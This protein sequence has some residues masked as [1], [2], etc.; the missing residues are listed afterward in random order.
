[1]NKFL[2]LP[3]EIRVTRYEGDIELAIAF[4]REALRD[5]CLGLCLLKAR[6]IEELI[7]T[8][9]QPRT[10]VK[11]RPG[12]KPDADRTTRVTIDPETSLLEISASHLDDALL[13]FLQYYRDGVAGVG[14]IHLESVDARTGEK[15]VDVTLRVP[16]VAP[17][18]SPEEL[19]R[20]L[21]GR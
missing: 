15:N 3:V 4:Q 1:V 7:I 2:Q 8:E 9:Q 21:Q 6:L 14:H 19:Q 18:I 13:F 12:T 17:S 16:D 20:R 11:I 10:K 5:W